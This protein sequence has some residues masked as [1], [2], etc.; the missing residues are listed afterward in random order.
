[1]TKNSN[2]TKSNS[3][4]KA[5]KNNK[6]KSKKGTPNSKNTRTAPVTVSDNCLKSP[7]KPVRAVYANTLQNEKTRRKFE[8]AL[9]EDARYLKISGLGKVPTLKYAAGTKQGE[10]NRKKT[11]GNNVD[12]YAV[13][14]Y[15]RL[16]ILDLDCH[17]DDASSLNEQI[18]FFSEFFDTDLNKT[19]KV[20]TP[21]GGAHFYLRMPESVN[22]SD[23]KIPLASLRYY[24]EEFSQVTKKSIILDA[25]LRTSLNNNFVIGPT[26]YIPTSKHSHYS[27]S[28]YDEFMNSTADNNYGITTVSR[29]SIARLETVY[30]I[31][32]QRLFVTAN[33]KW[34]GED[35]PQSDTIEHYQISAIKFSLKK[36]DRTSFHTKRAFVKA[37]LHCCFS[38][39]AIAYACKQ[40]GINK[41]SH[42]GKEL[43]EKAVLYDLKRFVPVDRFHGGF[44]SKSPLNRVKKDKIE[45][46]NGLS[47]EENLTAMQER[48][49]LRKIARYGKDERTVYP[50]V[51]DAVKISED[52]LGN[53]KPS[54]QYFDCMAIFDHF[55]QPLSNVGARRILLT[56][57]ALTERLGLNAS[58][59]RQALRVLRNTGA[60][61]VVQRQRTGVA[62]TYEV[63]DKYLNVS[64]TA[65]LKKSWASSEASDSGLQEPIYFNRISGK[66]IK[67]FSNIETK[68]YFRSYSALSQL[69]KANIPA[70]ETYV[71]AGAALT[72]LVEE[73]E[74]LGYEMTADGLIVI[75]T[76]E[77]VDVFEPATSNLDDLLASFDAQI[78]YD[79]DLRDKQSYDS[80]NLD[81]EAER[82]IAERINREHYEEVRRLGSENRHISGIGSIFLDKFMSDNF[83][84]DVIYDFNTY[85][86]DNSTNSET[87]L[88]KDKNI[89]VLDSYY[90]NNKPANQLAVEDLSNKRSISHTD[91][92]LW[93][94]VNQFINY[95]TGNKLITSNNNNDNAALSNKKHTHGSTDPPCPV[96]MTI[97]TA[98]KSNFSLS[99]N[100][101]THPPNLDLN[102]QQA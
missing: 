81:L 21:S 84:D 17:N 24:N 31:K 64:L 100:Y 44:C 7:S 88:A 37:A 36:S 26:S 12:N 18:D 43:S 6:S 97:D 93:H 68:S 5:L 92:D 28:N 76:G 11:I 60:I 65:D 90:I 9:G 45:L 80:M 32:Q 62:P 50:R 47:M 10:F 75:E 13:I 79:R 49:K 54:Q 70:P 72:Y 35:S 85:S 41:D 102:C 23:L 55:L 33:K 87:L 82:E 61:S 46:D 14:P 52:L 99:E 73:A 57:S 91:Q 78:D 48:V 38:D 8:E 29:E 74:E 53:R 30:K 15:N 34:A 101:N 59:S 77:I 98:L 1:M 4:I 39:V 25:D 27:L 67:V 89:S 2:R 22:V 3:L 86:H 69:S 83:G 40:L 94:E 56:T 71:N 66:F 95:D 42:T 51:L 63:T 19:L 96:L 16:F 20:N 58:R